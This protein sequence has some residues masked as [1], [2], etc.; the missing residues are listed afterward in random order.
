MKNLKIP[1]GKSEAVNMEKGK[2]TQWP[3]EKGQYNNNNC[4][5]YMHRISFF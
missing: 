3:K 5:D 2:I 1:D 4:H